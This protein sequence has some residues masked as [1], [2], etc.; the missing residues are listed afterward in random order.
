M[1]PAL[2]EALHDHAGL[3]PVEQRVMFVM[4]HRL[5][6]LAF[7]PVKV[8]SVAA[9]AHLKFKTVSSALHRLE[10]RGYLE[11]R[12]GGRRLREWRLP[13]TRLPRR[14][15]PEAPTLPLFQAAA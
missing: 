14:A 15:I 3:T 6:V 1:T 9:E 10:R 7:R 12:P 8:E 4:A 13:F 2:T 5:D 11:S